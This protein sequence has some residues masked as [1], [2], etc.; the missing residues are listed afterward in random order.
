[1]ARQTPISGYKLIATHGYLE[2]SSGWT[3]N[4]SWDAVDIPSMMLGGSKV[5][6]MKP[7]YYR[8]SHDKAGQNTAIQF[9]RMQ[10]PLT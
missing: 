3:V 7:R 8:W 4:V 10:S 6:N 9:G 5:L 1:M 2:P